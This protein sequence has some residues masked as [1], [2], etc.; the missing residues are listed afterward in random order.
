MDDFRRHRKT[1][2]KEAG[3]AHM[4]EAKSARDMDIADRLQMEK[5]RAGQLW[6][7]G[8]ARSEEYVVN[9]F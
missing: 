5:E 8:R 6:N 4:L 3:F 1:V 2:D 7:I 9:L